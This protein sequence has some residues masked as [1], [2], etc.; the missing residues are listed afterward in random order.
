MSLGE[1]F[2]VALQALRRN[3]LRS[4]LTLLGVIIGVATVVGVV[5]VISGLNTY[6]KD[7][8]FGLNP[9]IVIFT[10]YGIIRNRSEF[11]MARKR[12]PV[13]LHEARVI[14]RECRTCIAVGAQAN[15][16]D[17]VHVGRKKISDTQIQG[18]TSNMHSMMRMDL[19]A[20]RFFSPVEEEHSAAVAIIGSE[21]VRTGWRIR[22]HKVRIR[23]GAPLTFPEVQQPSRH[24]AAAVTD[25]IWPC[26][27]LQWEWL[28]GIAPMVGSR[29]ASSA[30]KSASGGRLPKAFSARP[31]AW[32]SCTTL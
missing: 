10:K 11:I 8:L 20:G 32:R 16:V 7:K 27:E 17:A 14:E 6:V 9:D 29:R 13:T 4:F 3:K 28:G 1:V 18:Y 15:H 23:A 22:P 5:S 25:R 2:A 12:K 26:V 30:P 24:L 19:E 21:A 31:R